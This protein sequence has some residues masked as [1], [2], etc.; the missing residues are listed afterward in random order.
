MPYRDESSGVPPRVRITHGLFRPRWGRMGFALAW[1]FVVPTFLTI[2]LG[3]RTLRCERDPGTPIAEC[4]LETN[5]PVLGRRVQRFP[6][7]AMREVRVE[8]RHRGRGRGAT[9]YEVVF[10]DGRG[11]ET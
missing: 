10:L 7:S 3:S 1:L 8:P 2:G 11:S 5:N 4:T 6:S 9:E